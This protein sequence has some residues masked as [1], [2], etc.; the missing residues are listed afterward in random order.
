MNSEI[1]KREIYLEK[2]TLNKRQ[3]KESN[4]FNKEKQ[5]FIKKEIER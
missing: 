2:E 3:E 4:K 1:A 5:I